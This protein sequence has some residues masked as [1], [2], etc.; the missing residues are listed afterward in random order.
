MAAWNSLGPAAFLKT[1][2]IPFSSL[3]FTI[4]DGLILFD[5]GQLRQKVN[6]EGREKCGG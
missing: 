6:R 3:P 2:S 5:K 4:S 1:N